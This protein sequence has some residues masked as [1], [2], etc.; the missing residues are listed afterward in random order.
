MQTILVTGG[1]GFI[2]S[3][4]V[5]TLLLKRDSKVIVLDNFDPFYD[6][7]IKREN[8][9]PFASSPH[10]QL[11]EGDIL[12][13]GIVEEVIS[14]FKPGVI[15]H[16][17][18]LA[19]VRP[20]LKDPVRYWMVNLVGTTHLLEVAISQGVQHFVFG[21]SSSVY[22]NISKVP[23]SE[24]DSADVPL[25]PYAATKR[26]GELLCSTYNQIYSL[27]MTVLRF[28]TVYGPSQR[29][30]M[31]I[32]KFTRMIEE[33]TPI[34]LY[35]DGGM[36]RDYTYVDDIVSGIIASI[37]RPTPG[38][39][40]YNLG[41]SQPVALRDLVQMIESSLGKPAKIENLPEQPGDV[42]I[43]FADIQKARWNL[44]F[45]PRVGIQEG[46]GRFVA[47]FR[48]KNAGKH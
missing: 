29:P 34:P 30:E 16:L 12:N 18:A 3:H 13:R 46:I 44:G 28:F 25:S 26:A 31:A 41:N 19:G 15:I 24:S 43:T 17:A 48:K 8:I 10:F 23:F 5:N 21:S 40:I 9:L 22:G 2:G 47:W 42:Q 32:H 14:T 11:V 38:L 39:E 45:E 4:L 37:D 6:P 33:G 36:L 20:S 1:A 27:P 7:S 35:G